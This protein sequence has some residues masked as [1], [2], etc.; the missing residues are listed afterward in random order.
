MTRILVFG[1]SIVSGC[2]DPA[3][4]WVTRL[5][6]FIIDQASPNR[7]N[8]VVYSLGISRNASQ[9]VLERIEFETKQRFK[10]KKK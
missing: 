10:S 6:K 4:G 1:A 9:E 7:P 8:H 5:R 2:G 3:G